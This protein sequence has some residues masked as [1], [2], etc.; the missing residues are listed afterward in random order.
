MLLNYFG[1]CPASL[2]DSWLFP[3]LV[4]V[5]ALALTLAVSAGKEECLTGCRLEVLTV[6]RALALGKDCVVFQLDW[7]DRHP[8]RMASLI[9]IILSSGTVNLQFCAKVLGSVEKQLLSKNA[10]KNRDVIYNFLYQF[11]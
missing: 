2:R 3:C 5:L 7:Y 11:T 10:F 4:L 8:D 9:K 1:I 6:A